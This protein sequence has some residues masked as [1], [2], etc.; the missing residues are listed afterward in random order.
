MKKTILC[1]CLTCLILA[2]GTTE[3][4]NNDVVSD[5]NLDRY[6]GTWYEIARFDHRFERGMEQTKASYS[7]QEDGTVKVVNSGIKDGKG[8]IA[9]GKGKLTDTPA[10][11]RVSFFGPFYADYR[12]MLLDRDYRYA[13]V[14]SG[15]SKYLW[16]LSRTPQLPEGAK[17][18]LLEEAAHRGYAVENLIWVKH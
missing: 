6:L 15:G 14:G 8:R 2:C 18:I 3:K 13:L 11:L 9:V 1:T 12:V 4:V 17:E 7:L 10:L 5:L 16:I